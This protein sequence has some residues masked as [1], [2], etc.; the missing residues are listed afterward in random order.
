MCYTAY[1]GTMVMREKNA[2]ENNELQNK[3]SVSKRKGNQL[4]PILKISSRQ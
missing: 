1:G 3:F 4:S 2:D